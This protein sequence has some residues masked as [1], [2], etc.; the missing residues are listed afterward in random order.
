MHLIGALLLGSVF[1]SFSGS[2]V[3][4]KKAIDPCGA[5][6]EYY[7]ELGGYIVGEKG[8][9]CGCGYIEWGRR[10]NYAFNVNDCDWGARAGGEVSPASSLAR[11]AARAAGPVC[12]PE[13][14]G[15]QSLGTFPQLLGSSLGLPVSPVT[16]RTMMSSPSRTTCQTR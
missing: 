7:D 12:A 10:G 3:P 1:S 2:A 14:E 6:T 8:W 16:A 9:T 4:E 13:T 11:A 15:T 5:L